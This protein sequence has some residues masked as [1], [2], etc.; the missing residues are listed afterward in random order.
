MNEQS[1]KIFCS[2]N[3]VPSCIFDQFLVKNK[4]RAKLILRAKMYPRA[5]VSSCNFVHSRSFVPSSIFV[6]LCT[7]DCDPSPT[8]SHRLGS[9]NDDTICSFSPLS[10]N[11]YYLRFISLTLF[12]KNYCIYHFEFDKKK[13]C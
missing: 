2:C 3:F 6:Q 1:C 7:F 10:K 5:K 4:T 12:Q 11:L 9:I 13:F 8:T